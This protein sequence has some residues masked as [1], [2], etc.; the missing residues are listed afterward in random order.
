ML[1]AARMRGPIASPL[2]DLL[3]HGDERHQQSVTVAH[4][5]D[6]VL[7]LQLR[8][9][10]DDL[11]LP[12]MV[13]GQRLVA[14]ARAAVERQVDV[15]VDETGQ[16]KLAGGVDDR[17]RRPGTG[18]DDRGPAGGDA[19]VRDDDDAIGD[20]GAA[21]AVDEG[22]AG[23]R[24]DAVALRRDERAEPTHRQIQTITERMRHPSSG[25]ARWYSA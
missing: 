12:R 16:D 17:S 14:I 23:D 11:L 6:A 19:S 4:G 22:G 10:E 18:V 13:L 9:L 24:R 3:A 7:Q 15:G 20:W 25:C 8:R 1:P 21:V 5:R 2:L